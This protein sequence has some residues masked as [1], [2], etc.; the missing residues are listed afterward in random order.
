[1]EPVKGLE[2]Y[3]SRMKIEESFKDL[4]SLLHLDRSMNKRRERMEKTIAL[5]LIAHTL[6][7]VVGE[8][9]RDALYAKKT[10]VLLPAL[11]PPET[12]DPSRT[13]TDAEHPSR[14]LSTV[15]TPRRAYCPI[16]AEQVRDIALPPGA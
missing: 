3:E 14:R 10:G 9:A 16:L 5:T 11:R 12:S 13:E 2:L 15:D 8:A 4:K 6:S 7:Y 1:L